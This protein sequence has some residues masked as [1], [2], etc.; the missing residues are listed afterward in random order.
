MGNGIQQNWQKPE[1]LR[2]INDSPYSKISDTYN[3]AKTVFDVANVL[4]L[5]S[6]ISKDNK[7]N[8][9]FHHGT[10]P[11]GQKAR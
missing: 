6:R 10:T 3:K 5:G 2:L 11:A 1:L 9:I 8:L 4:Y 7:G